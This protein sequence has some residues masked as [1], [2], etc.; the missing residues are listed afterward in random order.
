MWRIFEKKFPPP[1]PR[2]YSELL[3]VMELFRLF[4]SFIYF[5]FSG[6]TFGQRRSAHRVVR[7]LERLQTRYYPYGI[8]RRSHNHI[9]VVERSVQNPS[10]QKAGSEGETFYYYKY[11]IIQYYALFVFFNR[12]LISGRCTTKSSF[13]N[14][15]YQRWSGV[16]L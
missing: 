12:Y 3:L 1:S 13:K 10:V 11:N 8:L 7:T 16:R 5:V 9:P 14:Q 15:Y 6:E 4:C 2:T